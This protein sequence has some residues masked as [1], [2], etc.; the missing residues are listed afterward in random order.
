MKKTLLLI[1]VF[2]ATVWVVGQSRQEASVYLGG[3]ISSLKCDLAGSAKSGSKVGPLFGIGYTYKLNSD[4]GIV[5]G[6]EMAIYQTDITSSQLKDSYMTKDNYGNDFEWR[7]G[8]NNLEENLKSTY[9]NIPIMLRFT[10]ESMDKLY[11]SFGLKVGIPMSGKYES[12][13]SKLVTSGYYPETGA[14][15]TDLNFRGFGE[16]GGNSV[17]GDI[18]T[19]L[20]FI[21][22]AECGLKWKLSGSTNLYAGGYIDY[23]LNN[24]AEVSNSGKIIAYDAENPTNFEYNSLLSSKYTEGTE[25]KP[26]IDKIYPFA[27]GLKVRFGFSL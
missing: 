5:S 24:I 20:A 21:L 10:P 25:T 12:K 11:A 13:Y 9:I 17:K 26:F 16:F 3:G 27:A 23:G 19:K 6:L 8:F 1:F 18:D 7:L 4:W 14:E 2:T 22:S 15:Y